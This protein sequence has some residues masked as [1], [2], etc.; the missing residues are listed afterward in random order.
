MSEESKEFEEKVRAI[1]NEPFWISTIKSDTYYEVQHDDT[2]G[3]DTGWLSV[4]F[5]ELGDARISIDHRPSLRFR[6]YGGG[7]KNIRTRIALMILA[8]AIRLDTM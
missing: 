8:E 5:D 1:L 6:T 2:D 4:M 7:G 3:K